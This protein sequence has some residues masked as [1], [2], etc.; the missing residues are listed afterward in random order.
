MV[1]ACFEP[2]KKKQ[3]YLDLRKANNDGFILENSGR[4]A[5]KIST[6]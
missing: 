2:A 6:H 4:E 1:L 5:R 3:K